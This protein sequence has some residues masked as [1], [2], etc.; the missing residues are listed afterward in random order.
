MASPT[1]QHRQIW[2]QQS[3]PEIRLHYIECLP[4]SSSPKGI[5]LLI[6]GFPETSYQFRHVIPP[7]AAAGYHVLA[8]DYRGAGYSSHPPSGYTKDVL[9]QDLYKLVTEH[10]GV[11]GKIHVVGHDIGGMIAHAYVAQFPDNVESII[12]GECPLPGS[13]YYDASKNTSPLWHFSFQAQ[14]DISEALVAGKEKI[15]IK[16]F[17]DRLSQNPA[18]FTNEDVE[19][20]ATQYSAP[21]ALRCAFLVYR[22]FEEDAAMNWDWLKRDGKVGVRAMNLSGEHVFMTAEALGMAKEYYSDVQKGIVEGSG[23]YLAEENP[24]G[25]IRE[26]LGFIERK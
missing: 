13:S 15:Y 14:P 25:F 1:P 24:E 21:G 4:P 8:P 3:N 19:F 10:V 9:A 17:Y 11:K 20:Y 12:W 5:I 18:A 26:V 22:L 2:L 23:H 16:H 6:H 7:L